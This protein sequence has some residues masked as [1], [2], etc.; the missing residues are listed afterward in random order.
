MVCRAVLGGGGLFP[1]G[2][3]RNSENLSLDRTAQAFERFNT[4]LPRP[5]PCPSGLHSAW[6][7]VQRRLPNG[8]QNLAAE[9]RGIPPIFDNF[10]T[11]EL[12]S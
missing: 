2:H 1:W 12:P 5:C 9:R 3:L 4:P 8:Y 11:H 10:I 6:L 7:A